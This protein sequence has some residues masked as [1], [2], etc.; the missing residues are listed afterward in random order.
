[1]YKEENNLSLVKDKVEIDTVAC[2]ID[3]NPNLLAFLENK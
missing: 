3:I 2:S 1:M